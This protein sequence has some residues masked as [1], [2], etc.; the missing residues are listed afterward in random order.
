[1][2]SMIEK[3]YDTYAEGKINSES[4]QKLAV[5]IETHKKQ[6]KENLSKKQKKLLLRIED[7]KELIT[8]ISNSVTFV[9]GFKMGLKIGYELCEE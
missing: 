4:I 9:A 7:E 6:L 3:I 5:E 8:E 1:M 2:E